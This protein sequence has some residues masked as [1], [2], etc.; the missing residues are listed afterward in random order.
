MRSGNFFFYA[1]F[2]VA[3]GAV[4]QEKSGLPI[5]DLGY[6]RHQ[7]SYLNVGPCIR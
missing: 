6:E 2:A 5:V 1:L 3:L 4:S 7:A